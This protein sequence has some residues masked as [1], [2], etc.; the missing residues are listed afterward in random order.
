M[1]P[2]PQLPESFPGFG[3][4]AM[5]ALK[6]QNGGRTVGS[7][8]AF[9]VLGANTRFPRAVHPISHQSCLYHRIE[10]TLGTNRA[11][12]S[13]DEED[14]GFGQILAILLLLLPLRDLVEAILARKLK[15]RQEELEEDLQEAIVREDF[16]GIKRAVERGCTFPSPQSS[17]HHLKF[18]NVVSAHGEVDY[19]DSL[20][21]AR[22]TIAEKALESDLHAAIES[23]SNSSI[24]AVH[25]RGADLIAGVLHSAEAAGVA[26]HNAIRDGHAQIAEF[27]ARRPGLHATNSF[28][29]FLLENPLIDV[30]LQDAVGHTALTSAAEHGRE[31]IVKLLVDRHGIQINATDK[32]GNTALTWASRK[33]HEGIVEML[34]KRDDI[35]PNAAD[36]LQGVVKI[37]L[38]RHDIQSNAADEDGKTPLIWHSQ[39]S[40]HV[41]NTPLMWASYWGIEGI[42]KTLLEREDIQ[43]NAVD[44]DGATALTWASRK[45]HTHIV[46]MLLDRTDIQPGVTTTEG[47]TAHDF[48]ILHGYDTIAKM[49]SECSRGG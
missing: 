8:M 43:P 25:E 44:K 47:R 37:L 16:N 46:K 27:H 24:T 17:D 5:L 23:K 3:L 20:R 14:W 36:Q 41:G 7:G 40:R 6:G 48:A 45:G 49:I 42:V 4:S 15:K 35:Q 1:S 29:G 30:E 2:G 22:L 11:L 34:L 21:R 33:G 39:F 9:G 28:P 10:L 13:D 19:F 38:D 12:Q 26:L 32:D 18:W 31:A